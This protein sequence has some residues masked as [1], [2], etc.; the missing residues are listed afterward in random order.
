MKK[1]KA[2]ALLWLFS[3]VGFMLH[4]QTFNLNQ[5]MVAQNVIFEEKDGL[6]AVEAEYFYKQT[7]TDLREWYRTTK[8]SVAVVGRDEDAN[9][10]LNASNSSYIE[11][12]PDTRV[13]HSDQLVRGVNF[14]NKPGQLAVVSY[15]IKFNS[16][17]RYY[18]WVRALSTGSE[19]NGL[20][21]GLN[22]TWPEHGQRMQWCDGKKY[23]MWESKQ[24]TKDEHCGVPHAIYLDVPKAGIHEVQFSM[25]EDG[26]EF[27]KF[28]L[29][30]NSN[31]VPIDK[32]PNMT[33][34]DGNLPSSY[35]SK[36]EPSY[37]NTIARKL[38]EN[39]FIAS[40][41][42][43]IDGTNFYKNGK[44]WLAI[45]PEQYKQAK[46]S[47]LFDF[48]SGTYDVIYVGV[49]ENDGRSTFR[50]VINNKELGTYQP[51]LTQMLW[52]EGKAFNGFWKNV[53]LNKGDTITVE[54][55]VASDGNEWTRGRWAGI[56]FAPVGQGYV[57]Q[58]SPSTYIFEK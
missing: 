37:F 19:D 5:P 21:V 53:K 26:F 51:P 27:D 55:Q 29:T 14:S 43:P 38:P 18:V 24:R 7:H 42:F 25:R 31:Y 33:L 10:Y 56:V 22:G 48:E 57:V 6:V 17:G 28:V 12:L 23:W 3:L 49:G 4:A 35:K 45:N 30:T 41:E 47:T 52:E 39:K 11:V 9:H 54:V 50:I 44:N 34:A 2:S 58:E 46:I 20:H 8:D 16:P 40:Q 13:T 36:S 1:S 15:K 32:G